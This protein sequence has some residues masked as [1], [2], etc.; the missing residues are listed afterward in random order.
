MNQL[1]NINFNSLKSVVSIFLAEMKLPRL[2]LLALTMLTS[3]AGAWDYEGHRIVNSAALAALPAEFPAFVRQPDAAERIAF[4]SGEPD[5]WRNTP[6]LPLKHCASPDHYFDLEQIAAAGLSLE[7]LPSLR[8]DFMLKFA[9][10]RFKHPDA[11]QP[12]DTGKDSDHTARWPGFAP[13]AI[14]ENY[15]RLKSAFSY[16]RVYQELGSPVEIANAEANVIYQMGVLGHYV[17]D[18]AQPLHLTI[19]HNGWVGENPNAHSRWPGLHAWIDG[20]FPAK[21]DIQ[22]ENLLPRVVPARPWPMKIPPDGRDPMFAAVL[23]FITAQHAFVLPLYQIEDKG[24][25]KA[26]AVPTSTIG[27]KFL[28]DRLLAGSQALAAIW[29]TAWKEAGPD[30]YLRSQLENRRDAA[31]K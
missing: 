31:A 12:I 16:L 29:F 26:S 3:S 2:I 15:A 6:D 8:Y 14:T 1:K 11:F 25:F 4:L 17:G 18:C 27:K 30:T 24:E 7:K 10:G 28:E 13:W 21:A 22:L 9:A 5:R 19:H 23:A 20:G